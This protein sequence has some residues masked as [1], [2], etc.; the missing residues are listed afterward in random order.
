ML[1]LRTEKTYIVC[2]GDTPAGV[3]IG[4][5]ASDGIMNISLDYTTPM[6]R[7][8]SVG[9]YLYNELRHCGIK[10]LVLV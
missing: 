2:C 4:E 9:E 3:L 7:D 5:S 10:E 6:Y 1:P 8:C